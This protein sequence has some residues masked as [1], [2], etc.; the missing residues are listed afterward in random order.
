MRGAAEVA[1]WSPSQLATL[2]EDTLQR[3]TDLYAADGVLSE[4]LA[5]ALASDSIAAEGRATEAGTMQPAGGRRRCS[6]VLGVVAV[7]HVL[8]RRRARRPVFSAPRAD[9][10]SPFWRH[11]GGIPMPTKA[12]RRGNWRCDLRRSTQGLRAFKA[13]LGPTWHSTAVVLATEFGRTAAINGTRGTDHGTGSA[14]FLLGGAI[15]GGRVLA[16]WPA[17]HPGSSL[18]GA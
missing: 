10:E 1:S 4:R 7:R 13:A 18:S 12:A 5:E 9:R 6:A 16:D 14:A 11:Q 8:R 3:V 2:S 15:S 17:L